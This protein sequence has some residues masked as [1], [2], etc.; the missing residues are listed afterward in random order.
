M[1]YAV[2]MVSGG[3]MGRKD[4]FMLSNI[5]REYTYEHTHIGK[6]RYGKTVDS[7]SN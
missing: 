1:N 4:L 7:I 3:V 2:E 5:K 6:R